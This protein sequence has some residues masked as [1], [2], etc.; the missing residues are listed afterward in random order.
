MTRLPPKFLVFILLLSVLIPAS[1]VPGRSEKRAGSA[2]KARTGKQKAAPPASKKSASQKKSVSGTKQASNKKGALAKQA[3]AQRTS[4]KSTKGKNA[5]EIRQA[6][7]KSTKPSPKGEA[8]NRPAKTEHVAEEKQAAPTKTI[9]LKQGELEKIQEDIKRYEARLAESRKAERNTL[10]RLDLYDRQTSLIK[11]V[12]SHLSA[13]IEENKRGIQQAQT[14]LRTEEERL[15]RLKSTYARYVVNAYKRGKAHDTELLLTSTSLNQMYI[16]SKY[17][18]AFTGRQKSEAEEIRQRQDAV[19]AQKTVLEAQVQKQKSTV[20]AKQSEEQTL[21][22]KSTEHKELLDQVRK[23]KSEYQAELKRKQAAA[24]K[25]ERLIASLIERERMRHVEVNKGKGNSSTGTAKT[26][27][28]SRGDIAELPGRPISQTAFGRLKG[29]LPWP[30]AK[31]RVVGEFGEHRNPK[32]GTVTMSS[33]ID[34]ESNA[35]APVRVVADGK[36]SMLYFIAG[37]GNLVIVNHDDGFFTVYARLSSIGVKEGQE[38]KAGQVIARSADGGSGSQ[39][40]F[41]L[42]RQKSKQN[43]LGWLAG[44]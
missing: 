42:W 43:P 34:I 44:R 38:V 21:Q 23:D 16:R 1:T 5:P 22:R 8:K 6:S 17:L 10:E 9:R 40:H 36:V 28:H 32:L 18:K 39:V 30:V 26:G 14:N 15:A 35:G 20:N 2:L 11:K 41:E 7:K 4:S 13:E 33:G 25:I 31:G 19:Q 12:V 24:A 37:Y 3:A 27:T 29:R